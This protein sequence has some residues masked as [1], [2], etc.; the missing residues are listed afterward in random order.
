MKKAIHLIIGLGLVIGM[1]GAAHADLVTNGGFE[2]TTN[3][4]GQLGFNTDVVGWSVPAGATSSYAF[5]FAPGTA[6]TTGA[7]G[8]Y[9]NVI[10]HGPGNGT[11]NG[12]PAASPDGG[13]FI[14]SDGGFQPGAITQTINGLVAGQTYAVSFW[15]GAAQQYGFDGPT[16]SGWEVSLGSGPSQHTGLFNLPSHDFSGWQFTTFNF[17]ADGSSDVLSFLAEGQPGGEPPFSLLDGVSVSSPS[18]PEGSSLGLFSMGLL[19]MGG[20]GVFARR[21]KAAKSIS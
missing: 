8:Q 4:N 17:V 16:Q 6:D 18:T 21:K 15:W 12:L 19:S 20:V 14:A 7:N 5:V 10:L 3:G 2:T 11:N 1:S 9:G 13:N